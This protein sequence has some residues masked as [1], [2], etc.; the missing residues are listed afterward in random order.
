VGPG[1][2]SERPFL[3]GSRAAARG[4]RA[5]WPA[6]NKKDQDPFQASYQAAK[7]QVNELDS[8]DPV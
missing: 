8:Q 6:P 7:H 4:R 5:E 3:T 2:S 1:L